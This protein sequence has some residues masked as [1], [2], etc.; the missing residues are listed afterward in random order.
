M[1]S[2]FSEIAEN[3]PRLIW[4][5]GGISLITFFGTILILPV[6]LIRIPT[7]YFLE[8]EPVNR[9]H[10]GAAGRILR[11]L[12]SFMKN[13]LGALLLLTGF[14]MLFTPGQGLL[15]LL[16][17]LLIMDFPGKRSLEKR[18]ISRDS[19][20]HGINRIRRKAGK[21]DLIRP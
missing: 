3:N 16:A 5:A 15:T 14:I 17:G 13:V 10:A 2:L 4:Y 6:I 12:M 19:I 20:F 21:P 9:R 7:D 11:G 1:V 8:K 18:L